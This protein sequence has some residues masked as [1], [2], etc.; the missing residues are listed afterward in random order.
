MS[1]IFQDLHE[2]PECDIVTHIS[3]MNINFDNKFKH[4]EDSVH[5]SQP[6]VDGVRPGETHPSFNSDVAR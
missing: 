6:C 5:K 1:F 3:L 4:I 2:Y